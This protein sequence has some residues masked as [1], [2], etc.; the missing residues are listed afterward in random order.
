MHAVCA[1]R[2]I[3]AEYHSISV[4]CAQ[5][6]L[7]NLI[8]RPPAITPEDLTSS[9][10]DAAVLRSKGFDEFQLKNAQF[11]AGDLKHAGYTAVQLRCA[12]FSP[13]ELRA[14]GFTA[15]EVCDGCDCDSDARTVWTP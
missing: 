13:S 5:F 10:F 3:D 15:K 7:I 1:Y 8:A 14:G 2:P 9:G 4:I 6:C 11:D 12:G